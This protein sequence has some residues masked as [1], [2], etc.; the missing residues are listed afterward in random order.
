MSYLHLLPGRLDDDEW[1][2]PSRS[3]S[4]AAST[5]PPSSPS[6]GNDEFLTLK[7]AAALVGKRTSNISYLV[8]CSHLKRYNEKGE[9]VRRAGDGGLRVSKRELLGYFEGLD[10]RV[11]SRL[12]ALNISDTSL[13]FLD[14][15]E[16]ERTK[17]VH[18]LHPYLGKFIPQLVGHF[19]SRYFAP[20]ERVLDPFSG[21]GTTLV[22]AA[23][24]GMDS[25]GIE[26]SEFNVMISR[27]KLAWYDIPAVKREVLDICS[28]TAEFSAQSSKMTWQDKEERKTPSSLSRREEDGCEE[29]GES[30]SYLQ[31]W[32]APRTLSELLFF[33]DLI[34]SYEHQDLLR[35]LLSR[36]ARSCRL[37]HHYDLATPRVP[38]RDPY[39]CYKHRGK[40]CRPVTTIIP[41]LRFYSE[42]TVRRIME[43]QA[44]RGRHTISLVVEGDAR[45]VRL[46][47]YHPQG[48][49]AAGVF[50]SPPYVGQIDYHEQHRYAYELFGIERR[51]RLEIGPKASGK[52]ERARKEYVKGMVE[53]LCNVAGYL[54]RF[55]RP[56]G[57]QR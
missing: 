40:T 37:V 19:L 46:D 56:A 25:T 7:D 52:G 39:P 51:D 22:E 17:H 26:L 33:R 36:T 41:R 53:S 50:T 55:T 29:H 18:R 49:R 32:F 20:G 13:A 38:V 31:T 34:L 3:S 5:S 28:R 21:S 30:S 11:K 9:Q 6:G 43:F 2:L 23:E 48:K 10:S 27:V 8:Q 4:A 54:S 57:R 45:S 1:Q 15:P 42:D 35:V 47:E 24:R 44:I 14:M 16:R 12:S